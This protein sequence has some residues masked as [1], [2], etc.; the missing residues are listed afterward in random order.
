[1]TIILEH[2]RPK[3][4]PQPKALAVREVCLVGNPAREYRHTDLIGVGQG[5][6]RR[7]RS[8]EVGRQGK[9]CPTL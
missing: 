6:H 3:H 5:L 4:P 7:D 2:P 1:M 8:V 9:P